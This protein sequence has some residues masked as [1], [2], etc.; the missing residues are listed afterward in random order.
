MDHSFGDWGAATFWLFIAAAAVAGSWEKARRNSEKHET[1]RRIIEKTGSIDEAKL[2]ALFNAPG[3][4]WSGGAPGDGYR[5]LR[6]VGTLLMGVA[7]GSALVFLIL[8]QTDVIPRTASIIGMSVAG[9]VV[10]VG[11]GFFF[12]SQFAEPPAN[13]RDGPTSR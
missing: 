11:L 9:G 2:K 1:M 6:V 13:R 4:D 10:M 3:S 7:A 5:A 8:G 12:S